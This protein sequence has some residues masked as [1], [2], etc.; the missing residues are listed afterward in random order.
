MP[1]PKAPEIYQ[2][3]L[4][5]FPGN[6]LPKDQHELQVITTLSIEYAAKGWNAAVTI[7]DGMVRV[8]AVPQAGIAPK[9]Y[10]LGLLRS[11]FIEDALPGLE[12]MFGMVDDPDI[13]YNSVR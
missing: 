5:E 1:S 3:P 8:I 12:A 10:L 11:G 13:A 7:Q 9:D 6:E 2:R 4:A